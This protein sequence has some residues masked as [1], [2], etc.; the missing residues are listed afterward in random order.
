M[1]EGKVKGIKITDAT[2]KHNTKLKLS[3]GEGL[4]LKTRGSCK[5]WHRDFTLDGKRGT[6]NIGTYPSIT[7][8]Q[9]RQLN[10][11][12]KA[13]IKAGINPKTVR[14]KSKTDEAAK[15]ESLKQKEEADSNTFDVVAAK[16]LESMRSKWALA[17]YQKN[18]SLVNKGLSLLFGNIPVAE[19]KRLQISTA[20]EQVAA[21]KSA[22][23]A[24]RLA[25]LMKSILEFA[26]NSG[27]IEYVPMGNM[28]KV[29]PAHTPKKMVAIADPLKL[30]QLLRGIDNFSGTFTVL[31]ALKLLPMFASRSGEFRQARWNEIS[32]EDAEWRIPPNHRKIKE[33]LKLNDEYTHIV[34]LPRQVIVILKDLHQYTG[35]DEYIFASR[36]AKTG[37]MGHS[38]INGALYKMG[39]NGDACGH[40][41]RA[42]LK[43]LLRDELGF[44]RDTIEKQ[45][46]HIVGNP[47]E[48]SYDRGV[49]STE[50]RIMMQAWADYLDTL[51]DRADVIATSREE[52]HD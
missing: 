5:S 46:S 27:Y 30:G 51:R 13:M 8:A 25:K 28:G 3:I 14:D 15:R 20:L 22:D 6:Y 18:V 29:L 9:A 39:Y 38:T 1:K 19:L 44:S 12:G 7:L 34:P 42:T 32:F 11:E 16:W 10:L 45:L 2:I 49:L 43:T 4:Y 41:F 31:C 37:H 17:T 52:A 48:A 47:S 50:R 36:H 26:C 35:N 24:R 33:H 40:G 21:N 23:A